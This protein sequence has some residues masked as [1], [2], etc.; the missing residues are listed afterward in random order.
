[1][2]SM[3]VLLLLPVWACSASSP[4]PQPANV[5]VYAPA[6]TTDSASASYAAHAFLAAFDS[7]QFERFR[8]YLADDITMFFP[9]ADTPARM[10]GR[11][12]VEARFQRFFAE[13]RSGMAESDASGPP[14]LGIVPRDLR[15]QRAG[16]DAVI[17]S[18]H[19]G[20]GSPA[21]RSLVFERAEAGQWKLI[22][23]HA[24]SPPR[25]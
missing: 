20:G 24:S 2:R 7:L 16:S 15:V 14:R 21:R 4:N 3:T 25:P 8:T 9:F 6:F 17:V 13:T 19:L 10:D 5:G 22:H 18:F 11:E 1:M 12:A 23:W